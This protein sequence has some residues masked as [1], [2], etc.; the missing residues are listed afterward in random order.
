[1][2]NSIYHKKQVGLTCLR[3][4]SQERPQKAELVKLHAR[5]I[6]FSYLSCF[7]WF[8]L[9]SCQKEPCHEQ[10]DLRDVDMISQ[11]FLQYRKSKNQEGAIVRHWWICF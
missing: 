1:M 6:L 3:I 7:R 9:W 5:L 2:T 8:R 10:V 4:L 11:T